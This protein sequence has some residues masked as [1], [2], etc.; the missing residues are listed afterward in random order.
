MKS[1]RDTTKSQNKDELKGPQNSHSNSFDP[2]V[3]EWST[4]LS[5][6]PQQHHY[7]HDSSKI[8]YILC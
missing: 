8:H 1:P 5:H 6:E 3:P 7:V 4:N 2:N